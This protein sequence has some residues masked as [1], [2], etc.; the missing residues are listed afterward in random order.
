MSS[1]QSDSDIER[2]LEELL[3]HDNTF[4]R[5]DTPPELRRLIADIDEVNNILSRPL[6]Q[7]NPQYSKA[8]RELKKLNGELESNGR[9]C[10]TPCKQKSICEGGLCN[11]NYYCLE[12]NREGDAAK[13]DVKQICLPPESKKTVGGRKTL[14]IR[15]KKR[16][17]T[18]R[19][20]KHGKSKHKRRKIKRSKTKRHRKKKTSLLVFLYLKKK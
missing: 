10:F 12:S 15:V 1:N 13:N 6:G 19:R 17:K 16:G 14:K 4:E 18:K 8:R 9:P 20:G 5:T 11:W 2:E 3:K 7:G